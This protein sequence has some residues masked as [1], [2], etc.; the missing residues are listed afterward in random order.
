[1]YS[2]YNL[3]TIKITFYFLSVGIVIVVVLGLNVG[4]GINAAICT[5]T[6]YRYCIF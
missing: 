2:Q 1:M 5:V 6:Q 4:F 3:I